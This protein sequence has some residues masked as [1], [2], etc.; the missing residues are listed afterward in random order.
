[1]R[2]CLLSLACLCG[3]MLANAPAYATDTA[4]DYPSGPV[5]LV[6]AY[7]PGGATDLQARI[8]C[9]NISDSPL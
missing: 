4:T 3:L 2:K 6:V 7:T 5:S 8:S 9:M 1:M